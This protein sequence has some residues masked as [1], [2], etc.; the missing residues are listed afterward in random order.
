V[1]YHGFKPAE[2]AIQ[3]GADE[4]LSS[5]I[6]D[7]VIVNAD[8]NSSAAIAT[9][10]VSGALTAVGS[11]GLATSA[12]TDTTS[13][14]N[15][16]SGTLAAAR[17]ATLNQNTT[18]T[19]ATVTTAAQPNITSVGTL[20]NTDFL[21][22]TVQIRSSQVLVSES[23]G[24]QSYL[25]S[26]GSFTALRTTSSHPLHLSA[27]YSSGDDALVIGTDKNATFAGSIIASHSTSGGY[28]GTISNTHASG[29]GLYVVGGSGTNRAFNVRDY[30]SAN[31]LFYVRGNGDVAIG[32]TKKL[33][34]DGG[35]N[36]Y[37]SEIAGDDIDI[38]AGGNQSIQ[39]RG[40]NTTFAGDVTLSAN[41]SIL[42]LG[43]RFRMKSDHSNST[44]WFGVGSTLNN[45]K[46]GDADFTSA[47]AEINLSASVTA[48]QIIKDTNAFTGYFYNDNGAGQG[49]HIKCKS[50][51]AGQTGRYLIKAEG[52]GSS[53][54]FTN[55]FLVDIDGNATFGGDVLIND[56]LTVGRGTKSD[57]VGSGYCIKWGG[58][59]GGSDRWGF[60]VKTST[61]NENLCLDANLAGT[62][63]QVLEIDKLNG[64]ATF[65]GD[66]T[67]NGWVYPNK[68]IRRGIYTSWISDN[69]VNSYSL[70]TYA[71]ASH[72]FGMIMVHSYPDANGAIMAVNNHSTA[73]NSSIVSQSPSNVFEVGMAG[74]STK[75][76]T[77][78]TD[79]KIKIWLQ[80][81]GTNSNDPNIYIV[82]RAGGSRVVQLTFI[83]FNN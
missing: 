66:V 19:A 79:G 59:S 5:H 63:H 57:S 38:V 81:N 27:N 82:N 20:G 78:A 3:I 14:S 2:Q 72:F 26:G 64:N 28:A 10:K 54:G 4:I 73:N 1:A 48:L 29:Y 69:N 6:S 58:D 42:N 39:V 13:A 49:L 76:G 9:S 60:R 77:D 8:I 12:T 71:K 41:T 67:H 45:F 22:D 51:D 43:S 44:G 47:I 18:G 36:S 83:N 21:S 61:Y 74:T 46:F 23:G 33:Y 80:Q 37:I 62:P 40:I 70:Q 7:G 56:D 24:S 53:G 15:I 17:V 11:H 75:S 50:N 55:N 35:V 34:L 52:W 16:S 65:S 68:G 32:A 30:N 31:D 25:Y